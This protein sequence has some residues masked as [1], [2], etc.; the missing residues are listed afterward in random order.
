MI[1]SGDIE[2]ETADG[3]ESRVTVDGDERL[4]ADVEIRQDGNRIVVS[5]RGEGE[6]RL[7]V[8]L[9]LRER[10]PARAGV[11]PARR[12]RQGQDRL[13]GHGG[14]RPARRLS[15]SIPSRAT[16]A[17]AARSP[18][19][20][21]Q[22][23]E[24][25]RPARGGRRDDLRADRLRRRPRRPDGRLRRHEDGVGRHPLRGR[26]PGRSPLHERLRRH[27]DR[28]RRRIARRRRRRTRPRATSPP[29]CRS[30][31]TRRPA[32]ERRPDGRRPGQDDQ[33][34]R[35]DLPGVRRRR[36]RLLAY[37]DF[38]FLL[39]AEVT[40]AFGDWAM[41]IV[42][43]RLDEDADRLGRPRRARLLRPRARRALWPARRAARRPVQAQADDDRRRT[44]VLAVVGPA[45]AV[46][47]HAG[48]RVADLPRCR[49][50]RRRRDGLLSGPH[51]AS[52]A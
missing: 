44:L 27:R 7:L 17:S 48:G 16:S 25:G 39:A 11:D 2:I 19:S 47:P 15:R 38:R 28:H 50:L 42:L 41:F 24:R 40:S 32:T 46:R 20:R 8:R 45:V 36:E 29:R 9:V 34:R 51:R 30:A 26:E 35:T 3:E 13:G 10:R 12:E 31:A 18:A 4:L 6:L 22:D 21:P 52:C 5:Y 14:R 37:R 33:R 49:A 1:P 23:R 43:A